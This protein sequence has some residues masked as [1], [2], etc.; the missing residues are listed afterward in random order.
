MIRSDER[1]IGIFMWWGNFHREIGGASTFTA[2]TPTPT[3]T[4]SVFP[5]GSPAALREKR[6][7]SL[8]STHILRFLSAEPVRST[9]CRSDFSHNR[10]F[11]MLLWLK[12]V[13]FSLFE[14]GSDFF[15]VRS[16]AETGCG[17]PYFSHDSFESLSY[18]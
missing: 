9:V 4:L 18:G 13:N 11:Y 8:R 3:A 6:Q 1:T 2:F 17:F 14:C 16:I 15:T 5:S 7:R 10:A 12:N